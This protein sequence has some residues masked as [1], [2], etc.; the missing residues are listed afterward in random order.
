M[1]GPARFGPYRLESLLGRGGM[2]EVYRAVDTEHDRVVALKV[3]STH[4]AADQRYQER[5]RREAHMA[6]RLNE[7]HVI[8]IHRYGEIDGRLYLDM[9]LVDGEDL[10]AVLERDG[11]LE[12][13]RAVAVLEQ[14]AAALDAAHAQGLVHR[15]VKPSNVLLTGPAER[16]FPYL[17]D[18]G[19]A[20]ALDD[21]AGPGL[22][23]TGTALGSFEYMAPERFQEQPV[24]RRADVYSLACVLFECLTGRKVFLG[25]GLGTLM[26]AHLQTTP[27]APSAVRPGVPVAFD[28]VVATGLAKDPDRRYP[29]AGALAVA[30]RAALEAPAGKGRAATT[31][32]QRLAGLRWPGGPG[33][34]PVGNAATDAGA[35]GAPVPPD[36]RRPTPIGPIVLRTGDPDRD[37]ETTGPRGNRRRR[38]WAVVGSLLAAVVLGIGLTAFL[39]LRDDDGGTGRA[40]AGTTTATSESADPDVRIAP[41]PGVAQGVA[42]DFAVTARPSGTWSQLDAPLSS[43]ENI[44]DDCAST[45]T[46]YVAFLVSCAALDDCTVELY[47]GN[48][49]PVVRLTRDGGTFTAT[50]AA[51]VGQ[52]FA[53]DGRPTPTTWELR[54]TIAGTRFDPAIG[55][56]QAARLVGSWRETSSDPACGTWATAYAFDASL[57]GE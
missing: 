35:H 37:E 53:C 8:P 42:A 12:P 17:V 20:R 15:D 23:E 14:V 36:G 5:F 56:S 55:G 44:S 16:P 7:P 28:A 25:D 9:R 2:G 57:P 54:F 32:I 41:P 13:A 34:G 39:V 52:E 4:L 22:T 48:G 3:L 19:I 10:A 49:Y 30:A 51:P 43:C 29:T 31:V 24:D 45:P 26:I 33:R 11:P 18:F 1:T 47:P 38:T 46:S 21:R 50:G 27:P 40:A 6:A